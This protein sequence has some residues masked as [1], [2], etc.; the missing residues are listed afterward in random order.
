MGSR[1]NSKAVGMGKILDF[2]KSVIGLCVT[3]AILLIAANS[4]VGTIDTMPAYAAVYIDDTSHTYIALPCL[5]AWQT[6]KTATVDAIRLAK[7]SEAY[8]LKYN[9][10]E[11]CREAG[12]FAQGGPGIV[13]QYLTDWGIVPP[14]HHWWDDPYR[15][16][17]GT[18]VYP[19]G[20]A[21][22]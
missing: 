10:D 13:R 6:K 3:V 12:G 19:N 7:A 18:V 17:D 9:S 14:L 16:E 1:K 20:K 5:P 4:L 22:G 11:D 8:A 21:P 15:T 2:G